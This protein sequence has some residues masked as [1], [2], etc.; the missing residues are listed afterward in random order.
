MKGFIF[1]EM[2]VIILSV[3]AWIS[4]IKLSKI[5]AEL[6]IIDVLS[7]STSI[8]RVELFNSLFFSGERGGSNILKIGVLIEVF[9][10][11]RNRYCS[12]T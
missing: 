5:S 1:S 10:N 4:R 3:L 9:K 8:S 2:F 6:D 12:N 7:G 11:N